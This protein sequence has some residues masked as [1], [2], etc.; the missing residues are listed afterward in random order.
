MAGVLGSYL[1]IE[2]GHRELRLVPADAV[3]RNF[4]SMVLVEPLSV[5]VCRSDLR[6][7]QGTRSVR[8]DFGHEVVGRVTLARDTRFADGDV[9][10]LDPHVELGYRSTGFGTLMEVHGTRP[11]VEAALIPFEPG[12]WK[13]VGVFVEPLACALHCWRV[14]SKEL[15]SED[16]RVQIVGAGTAGVLLTVAWALAGSKV[17]LFNRTSE[18][19]DFLG[20]S[21]L[22]ELGDISLAA[23]DRPCDVVIVATT[24][25]QYGIELMG[26]LRPGGL[27]VPYGGTT[28][29]ELWDGMRV[30][31]ARRNE[32]RVSMDGFVVQGT[33]GATHS[34]FL[35]AQSLLESRYDLRE[36]LNN[37][38]V[39]RCALREAPNLLMQ[40]A[41]GLRVSKAV[42]N[43]WS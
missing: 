23:T 42:I 10:V 26:R 35:L 38:V 5:G 36:L 27:V 28:P 17:W 20:T 31:N 16:C 6:E 14:A 8:S 33:Y 4:E 2:P 43:E 29:G 39:R 40:M 41:D 1:R 21:G 13:E 3:D 32:G 12:A 18:R 24:Q 11:A 22:L 30:D 7:I 34:D 37:L 25:F 15:V 19:I 9:V